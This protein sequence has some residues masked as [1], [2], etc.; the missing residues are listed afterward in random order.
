MPYEDRKM[1]CAECGAEF[2][3]TAREQEFYA[4]K[5]YTNP[6][7]RCPQCRLSRRRE[8]GDGGHGGASGGPS[9]RSSA[10]FTAVCAECGK[11]AQLPFKPTSNRP[12]Y[13]SDCFKK[14]RQQSR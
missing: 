10:Q 3:F 8:R 5:G 4:E 9:G 2:A 12:V 13:C 14:R 6:P 1:T 7:K 11:E